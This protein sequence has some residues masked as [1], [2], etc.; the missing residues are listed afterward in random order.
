MEIKFSPGLYKATMA[1][2]LVGETV[3]VEMSAKQ[4]EILSALILNPFLKPIMPPEMREMVTD[5]CAAS[6]SALD[7]S[8]T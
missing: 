8:E 7:E 6:Q 1:K 5:F 2:S 4:F 3:V